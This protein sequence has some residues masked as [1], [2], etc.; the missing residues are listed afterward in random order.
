[1]TNNTSPKAPV[2]QKK[3]L[4]PKEL[5]KWIEQ[6]LA[7]EEKGDPNKLFKEIFARADPDTRRAMT[8]RFDLHS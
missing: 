2:P 3:K 5:E 7:D 8:K 1:M 6:E 4:D